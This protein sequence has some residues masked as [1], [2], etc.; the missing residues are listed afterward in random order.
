MPLNRRCTQW[1]ATFTVLA[2]V[3][4]SPATARAQV[5]T[6][7]NQPDMQVDAATRA[8][9]LDSIVAKLDG[10][11]VIPAVGKKTRDAIAARRKRH[12]YDRITSAGELG[13][14]LTAHLRAASHDRHLSVLY[15]HEPV[16]M[17]ADTL[18]AAEQAKEEEFFRVRNYGFEQV[19]RLRGNVGYIRLRGFASSPGAGEAAEAAMRLVS[20]TDALIIDLRQNGGGNGEMVQLLTTYLLKPGEP[21][22]LVNVY[23]RPDN[24]T[25]Q[26]WTLPWVPGPHY[27]GKEVYLLTSKR[28]FSAAEEFCFNLQNQK[29][30]TIVGET[31]GGG[32]H[33]VK[34]ERLNEHFQMSVPYAR[35]M[36]PDTGLDWEGV[37]VRPD[38][39]VPADDALKTAHMMA[40]KKLKDRPGDPAD[41][42]GAIEDLEKTGESRVPTAMR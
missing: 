9:V 42:A 1:L 10:Q 28:T 18:T 14:S 16:P 32:A 3:T 21:V 26:S 20:S 27:L 36:N 6:R 40:L 29:R 17:S 37:G 11:Y 31:T 12:E 19:E 8:A 39:Q 38:V 30:V 15:S 4:G 41:V 33:P 25:F 22:H 5:R 34:F 2:A 7:P 35:S 23:S 24:A 13:D